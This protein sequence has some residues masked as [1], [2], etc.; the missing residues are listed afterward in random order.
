MRIRWRNFE[1]PSRVE[2]DQESLSDTFARFSIEP[3]EK[4]FGH[5]IGNGLRRVLLSSIE[6]TAVTSV[7]IDNVQHE[8]TSVPG[9]LE[10]VTEI[11]LNLKGLLVSLDDV[12]DVEL[13][14]TRN[15]KGELTAG[16]IECPAGI[17]VLN[18]DHVLCTLTD[19]TEV[20]LTITVERGRGYVTAEE[21]SGEGRDEIG[22]IDVDSNFSP[23]GRVRYRIEETRVGKITNY[24][25]LLLEIW[26]DG[27]VTPEDALV[28]AS[29]I[30]RKH[31]NAFVH[32]HD[33]D[34]VIPVDG[35]MEQFGGN[36]EQAG[37]DELRGLLDTP[38]D[39]LDLSVRSRH[40][41]DS[42]N[43]TTVGALVAR[44][45]AELLKV[46]NFGQTS[47][48][49]IKKKLAGMNL[50]LGMDLSETAETGS[51]A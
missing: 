24:D 8:F 46:R 23:V 29:R 15:R 34:K 20:G 3:F 4:G 30:Y 22:L 44:S 42:E 18:P 27:T 51:G 25:R 26:T 5:T 11:V 39:D 37:S 10:D 36:G 40:C 41:L 28:E 31:L 32:Y 9:V 45:D 50:T 7:R 13:R 12:D 38:I 2:A 47:L 33:L 43:I 14:V 17:S 16:Q 19:D 6:G 1:L 35:E 49:E 21:H 48:T